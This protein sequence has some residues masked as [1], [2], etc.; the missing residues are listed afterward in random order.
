MF[1]DEPQSETTTHYGTL[2]RITSA[3]KDHGGEDSVSW[4]SALEWC[5]KAG[6]WHT[7]ES[8]QE[9]RKRHI[10]VAIRIWAIHQQ[11]RHCPAHDMSP[12]FR[13][14]RCCGI[15]MDSIMWAQK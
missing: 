12:R 2:W 6:N 8:W 5:D 4:D 11:I 13:R 3:W 10:P 7:D 1:S 9:E 15:G 14:C